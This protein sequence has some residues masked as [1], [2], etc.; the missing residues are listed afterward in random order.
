MRNNIIIGT[1]ESALALWQAEYVQ[2][3][4]M[5]RY[6]RQQAD[7]LPITTKGD[8]VLD[9]SLAEIGGKGLFIKELEEALLDGRIDVA[10][11]SLK[12][13]PADL[14]EGLAIAA[15]TSR[16]DPRDA[17]VSRKY[18]R[19]E[20]L[21]PHAK[22]GTSSLRRQA[23][24][25]H[26]RPDLD[27]IPL[28]GNVNTRIR[29]LDEGE[30]DAIILAAAGLKR[31]GMVTRIAQFMPFDILLPAAGQ[32][33]MAVEVR[34]DDRELFDMLRFLHDYE[35]SCCVRSE[36]AFLGKVGGDC[37]VPAGVHASF[38]RPGYMKVEGVIASLD[39][40]DL[41]RRTVK[42]TVGKAAEM[43]STLAQM[44]LDEGGADILK[45]I[46]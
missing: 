14:P 4:I 5:F 31:L 11:H 20:D 27:I 2:N 36:R 25:L 10:V 12:D 15:V 43:G 26:V 18:R 21:P 29:K 6:S 35:E 17:F 46:E 1:R 34:K 13:M 28:R 8:K 22:V 42:G 7:L 32:G 3:Q 24:L 33:V 44:L 19:F 40:K 30:Y 37:R 16:E 45:S 9:R 41:V 23:Q 38:E 39:G